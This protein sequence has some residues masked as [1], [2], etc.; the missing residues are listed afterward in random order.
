MDKKVAHIKQED[1]EWGEPESFCERVEDHEGRIS[2]FK[3]EECREDREGRISAFKQEECWEDR[4]GRISAFK[5]EE[6]RGGTL[7]VKVEDSEDVFGSL[8]LRQPKTENTFVQDTCE[9]SPS[10]LQPCLT[11]M[12][13][14]AMQQNSLELKS[15]KSEFE[16]K[17]SEGNGRETE[18]HQSPWSVEINFQENGS[19]SPHSFSQTSIQCELEQNQ[20][21]ETMKKSRRGSKNL[22]PASFQCSSLPAAKLTRIDAIDSVQQTVCN[23]GQ[24]ALYAIQECREKLLKTNLT[25]K[26]S[27]FVQLITI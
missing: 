11:T 1:C 27:Q 2:A 4:E 26:I 8:E 20:D 19:F 25:L 18:K 23:T 5:E 21:M 16:E 12:V 6:C 7:Q 3:E 10:G 24:E 15:E 13:E 22:T 17:I 14:P 9:P